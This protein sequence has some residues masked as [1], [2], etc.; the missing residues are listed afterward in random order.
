[1]VARSLPHQ[2]ESFVCQMIKNPLLRVQQTKSVN[3]GGIDFYLHTQHQFAVGEIKSNRIAAPQVR[4]LSGAMTALGIDNGLL[5]T[6]AGVTSSCLKTLAQFNK[7]HQH[8]I[9]VCLNRISLTGHY[10]TLSEAIQV[11]YANKPNR[12]SPLHVKGRTITMCSH[13]V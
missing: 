11:I 10:T 6:H 2:F 13:I 12:P 4:D 1:M 9:V 5:I 3:D 7:K 8:I